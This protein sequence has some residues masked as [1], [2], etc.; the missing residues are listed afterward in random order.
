MA[1][2]LDGTRTIERSE[3]RR[4]VSASKP[5]WMPRGTP[6]PIGVVPIAGSS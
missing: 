6:A 2:P 1:A 3:V 4:H 5:P